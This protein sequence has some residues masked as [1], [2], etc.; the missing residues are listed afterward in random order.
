MTKICIPTNFNKERGMAKKELPYSVKY[1]KAFR[2]LK[3]E[4]KIKLKPNGVLVMK[5]L[6]EHA[7]NVT[8]LAFPSIE[9]IE[10]QSEL[11]RS[12]VFRALKRLELLGLIKRQKKKGKI[13]FSQNEYKILL[14][15]S[16]DIE[17]EF[18]GYGLIASDDDIPF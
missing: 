14:D 9:T 10:K 4:S 8:G 15:I 5:I 16:S 17:N 18:S 2:K 11:S 6:I 3:S 1:Q 12:S 13:S 7:N